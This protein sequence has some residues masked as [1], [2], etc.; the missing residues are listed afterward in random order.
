MIKNTISI[1]CTTSHT[2]IMLQKKGMLHKTI[3]IAHIPMVS[4]F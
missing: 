4:L 1:R 2:S 3:V